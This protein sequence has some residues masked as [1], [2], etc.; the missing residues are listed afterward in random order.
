MGESLTRHAVSPATRLCV[1]LSGG[2][3]SVVLIHLLAGLRSSLGFS[4]SAIHVHHGLSADADAWADSACALAH[5][6]EVPCDVVRV[7]V[8]RRGSKGLE[9]AARAV[10]YAVFEQADADLLC[11]A[12]HQNDQAETVL[13]QVLRG[14]GLAGIAAMPECRDLTPSLRLLR[15]LLAMSRAELAAYAKSHDLRWVDDESNADT[16]FSRNFLRHDILP[17]LAQRD[18]GVNASL[19]RLATHAAEANALLAELAECDLAHCVRDGGLDLAVAA[20][21]GERR[22][23]NAL[24]YWLAR[25]GVVADARAFDA[26]CMQLQS[27]S[28]A[29]PQLRW[30]DRQIRRHRGRLY[31]VAAAP[32]GGVIDIPFGESCLPRGWA[33]RLD[34]R[35][36]AD[37]VAIAHAG[38]AGWQLRPRLGGER[39]RLHAAGPNRELK[40]LYQEAGAPPWLRD[41]TPLLYCDDELVAV[42]GLGVAAAWR[43]EGWLPLWQPA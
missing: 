20:E 8:D 31:L 24:R 1:G 35:R 9:A 22:S 41:A 3:D 15:P 34:W 37:G 28:D 12:H 11:L 2:L 29:Q 36:C 4:L 13:M 21:L 23:R 14:N 10:R 39:L 38:R 27:A 32:S 19:A 33:G 16:R 17:M 26:F 6:L 30:R 42:P 43:G 25:Q 7:H 5:S 18:P 40:S